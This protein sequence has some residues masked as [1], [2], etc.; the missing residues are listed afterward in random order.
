MMTTKDGDGSAW[1]CMD[2]TA[3]IALG[4]LMEETL[5]EALGETGYLA[6]LEGDEEGGQAAPTKL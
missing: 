1:E 2:E 6:L 4:I 5:R 3:L